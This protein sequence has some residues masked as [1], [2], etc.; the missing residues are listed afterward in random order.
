MPVDPLVFV[1]FANK[2]GLVVLTYQAFCPDRLKARQGINLLGR[3][4]SRCS[5][6][7]SNEDDDSNA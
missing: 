5:F 7:D 3:I 1:F 4:Y 6:N 2:K